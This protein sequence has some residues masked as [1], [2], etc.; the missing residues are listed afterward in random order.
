MVLLRRL[1][2]Q[3]QE[4]PGGRRGVAGAGAGEAVASEAVQMFEDAGDPSSLSAHSGHVD[5]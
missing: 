5:C 1:S 3:L 2:R 4:K